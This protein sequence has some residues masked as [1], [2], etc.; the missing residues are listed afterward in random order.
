MSPPLPG[1]L[2]LPLLERVLHAELDAVEEGIRL[3]EEGIARAQGGAPAVALWEAV[4]LVK[5]LAETRPSFTTDALHLR[6][7]ALYDGG[8]MTFPEPRAMGAV[9]KIAQKEGYVRPSPRHELS[10][11]PACHRRAVRV[12]ISRVWPGLPSR[13]EHSKWP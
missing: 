13:G 12:W 2:E 6:L 9:M 5:R 10:K 11:R 8:A 3:R 4:A 7:E 1:Q